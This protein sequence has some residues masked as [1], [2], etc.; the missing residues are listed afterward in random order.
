MENIPF[1]DI[2]NI[3]QNIFNCGNHHLKSAASLFFVVVLKYLNIQFIDT[4]LPPDFY[5]SFFDVLM[6]DQYWSMEI[7]FDCFEELLNKSE[8]FNID[9]KQ[10]MFF[11]KY[12]FNFLTQFDVIEYDD[13]IKDLLDKFYGNF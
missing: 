4:I 1:N 2:V 3:I 9:L 5:E 11:G 7:C 6:G 8:R 12:L 10:S 13:K